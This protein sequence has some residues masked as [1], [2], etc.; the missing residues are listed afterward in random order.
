[1][2][3]LL[4]LGLLLGQLL[5]VASLE[6][7]VRL[8][9]RVISNESGEPIDDAHVVA[10]NRGGAFLGQALTDS[11]GHF[12]LTVRRGAGA[13]L[14][15]TRL[16]FTRQHT[17]FLFFDGHDFFR[18]ELRLDPEAL[19][20][21]PLEVVARASVHPS[22]MLDGFRHRL[23]NGMGYYIT[24]ADIERRNPMY[25]TDMLQMVPGVR[26]EGGGPGHRRVVQMARSLG[27][28]CRTQIFV[29]GFLVNRRIAQTGGP[30]NPFVLDDI[31]SPASVEGIEVYHGLSTVP[32]EFLNP[33]AHCGVI[34]VWTR[35]GG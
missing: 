14:L 29:D 18:I 21:A 26:L 6:A 10:R 32:A 11:L 23:T 33:D 3:T 30:S 5:A 19:L 20:L 31:V 4:L 15:A 13:R 8:V 12:E 16:G 28:N 35:R 34:A 24:R 25:V 2:R 27:R 17:P 1:M 9:G 7:Q 22:P